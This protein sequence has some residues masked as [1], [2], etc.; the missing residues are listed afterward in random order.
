MKYFWELSLVLEKKI[1]KSGVLFIFPL[2]SQAQN[3]FYRTSML[4]KSCG[5]E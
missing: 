5:L 1:A 3:Y 2:I 4:E